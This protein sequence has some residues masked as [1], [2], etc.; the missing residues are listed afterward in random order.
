MNKKMW[1]L[2]NTSLYLLLAWWVAIKFYFH[3]VW[4]LPCVAVVIKIICLSNIA[5]LIDPHWVTH[6]YSLVSNESKLIKYQY[7]FEAI[8]LA[9][10]IDSESKVN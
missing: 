7:Q 3:E 6:T 1:I 4:Q 5:V 9:G 2:E 10:F 8:I